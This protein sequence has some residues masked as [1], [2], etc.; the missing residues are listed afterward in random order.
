MVKNEEF[1]KVFEQ[2]GDIKDYLNYTACTRER[3]PETKK[4]TRDDRYGYS[5]RDCISNNTHR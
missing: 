2:T 3:E 4:E 5:Y 1:W